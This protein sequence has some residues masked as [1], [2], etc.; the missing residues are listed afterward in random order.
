MISILHSLADYIKSILGPGIQYILLMAGLI[1]FVS[2]CIPYLTIPY[3]T[4]ILIYTSMFYRN[5]LLV[6]S[7]VL[8]SSLGASTGKIV[9]YLI[10]K[11]FRKVIISQVN[12]EDIELFNRV[13]DKGIFFAIFL[14]AAT[15]LPDD[16]L[17]II[18][19]AFKYSLVKFFLACFMGKIVIT[20]F[21][22]LSGEVIGE[23]LPTSLVVILSILLTV[24]IIL[25]IRRIN[26]NKLVRT[27]VDY[28][29][30]KTLQI[31]VHNPR[32]F[33]KKK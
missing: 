5:T 15:P 29:A 19:G 9:V 12:D 32:Q 14:F 30:V 22:A 1:S 20:G 10:G 16:V 13:A 24:M 17:Y 7:I 2:N 23:I 8:I 28:G 33:I 27:L 3:L 18:I 31:I 11:L 4:I 6:I 25:I 26:W 21:V